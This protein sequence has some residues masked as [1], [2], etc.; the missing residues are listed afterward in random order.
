MV[1]KA[2]PKVTVFN[3][4]AVSAIFAPAIVGDFKELAIPRISV[5]ELLCAARF[6]TKFIMQATTAIYHHFSSSKLLV[7]LCAQFSYTVETVTSF[8]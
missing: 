5:K 2:T 4:Y 6:L 3:V 7:T 8:G 1:V